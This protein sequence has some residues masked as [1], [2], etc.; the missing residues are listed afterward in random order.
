MLEQAQGKQC[1]AAGSQSGSLLYTYEH[2]RPQDFAL[3]SSFSIYDRIAINGIPIEI[4]HSVPD[5][6]HCYFAP[7]HAHMSDV[8]DKMQTSCLLTGHIH[9][10][11]ACEKNGK[12]IFN[13]GS[14]GMPQGGDWR[15]Q[16]AIVCVEQGKLCCQ[17]RSVP[18]DRSELL[19]GQFASGLME[20]AHFWALSCLISAIT[21]Q[22]CT[23]TLLALARQCAAE[24]QTEMN[25]ACWEQAAMRMN[26]PCTQK[27]LMALLDA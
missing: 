17:M 2:L 9:K 24:A 3:F 8:A 20:Q 14:I 19:Q 10:Q 6:D 1:F 15:S 5:D 26:L 12:R 11:Y 16:Y 22:E 13:P 27:Q 25:E 18:Y 21:G 7:Q 4:A 23:L